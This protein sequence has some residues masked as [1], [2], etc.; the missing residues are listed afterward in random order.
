MDECY[1]QARRV[2]LA[3][4]LRRCIAI[5]TTS[6]RGSLIIMGHDGSSYLFRALVYETKDQRNKMI[7]TRQALRLGHLHDAIL[8]RLRAKLLPCPSSCTVSASTEQPHEPQKVQSCTQGSQSHKLCP[9]RGRGW[10]TEVAEK[11]PGTAAG[12][13]TGMLNIVKLLVGVVITDCRRSLYH[14]NKVP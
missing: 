12:S 7:K 8:K 9:K 10:T 3:S 4:C 11:K 5:R 6:A 14:I 1:A 2:V 13:K